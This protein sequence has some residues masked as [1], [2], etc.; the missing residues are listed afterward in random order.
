[1]WI[2]RRSTGGRR[3]NV[4]EHEQYWTSGAFLI[5]DFW[6]VRCM[7]LFN[8]TTN[9]IV[10]WKRSSPPMVNRIKHFECWLPFGN[11][12]MKQC[13]IKFNKESIASFPFPLKFNY[14][15]KRVEFNIGSWC[16]R[17]IPIV[18]AGETRNTIQNKFIEIIHVGHTNG[19]LATILLRFDDKF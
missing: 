18:I 13:Q 12:E 7:H 8:W 3:K 15:N 17:R 6:L 5:K 9:G 2:G 4:A 14:I 10:Q 16:A 11:N 19:S 1:M